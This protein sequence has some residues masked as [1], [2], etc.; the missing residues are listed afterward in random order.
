MDFS[1]RLEQLRLSK[2][3][4]QQEMADALGISR[5]AY[6]RYESG[7][8]LP[9]LDTAAAICRELKI[10]ADV[11]LDL[12][13]NH[14]NTYSAYAKMILEIKEAFGG[15]GTSI[16][17][18]EEDVYGVPTGAPG[19][20]YAAVL[21]I[22]DA[23]MGRFL[24]DNDRMLNLLTEGVINEDVYISWKSGRL[25]ELDIPINQEWGLDEIEAMI[26]DINK[27]KQT[28]PSNHNKQ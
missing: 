26:Y 22:P 24:E 3:K 1:K 23:I 16:Y 25:L 28:E 21:A 14:E 4:T 12:P 15:Y 10:S 5:Q 8:G 9:S 13:I 17:R 27:L 20:Y 7:A 6:A 19:Q 2:N 18:K 11:L